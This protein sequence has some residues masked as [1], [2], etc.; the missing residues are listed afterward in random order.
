MAT[1]RVLPKKSET[2]SGETTLA[3]L[4]QRLSIDEHALDDAL[5][6]QP[7]SFYRVAKNLALL[8]S[9][10]DAAKQLLAEEEA[11]A[12]REFRD[13]AAKNNDKTTEAELKNMIRLDADVRKAQKSFLDLSQSV[14]ELSA[15]K[16]AFQQRSYVLK[17]LVNLYISNYYS[18]QDGS[19]NSRASR[20]IRDHDAEK[21]KKELAR[22]RVTDRGYRRE[23]D[24]A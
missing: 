20:Q 5:T 11:R 1:S 3:E 22:A 21:A 19:D 2:P 15:L 7:D 10:R 16:E 17:D 23:S 24:D 4:E 14:G 9:R 8:I 12:D 18:N 13:V 6:Q